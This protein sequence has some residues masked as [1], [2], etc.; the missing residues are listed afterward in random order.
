MSK[1]IYNFSDPYGKGV[2]DEH[3]KWMDELF[4]KKIEKKEPTI[5]NDLYK[6]NKSNKKTCSVCGKILNNNEI[7]KCGN[8][9]NI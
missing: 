4:N 1:G 8:C 9:K 2:K 3:P 5:I 7:G 6:S